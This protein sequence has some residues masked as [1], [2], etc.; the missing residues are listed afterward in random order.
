MENNSEENKVRK[1]IIRSL[2]GLLVGSLL[3]IFGLSLT[4][5]KAPMIV[6]YIIA[7]LLYI[8]SLLAVYNN[9]KKDKQIIYI[10]IMVVAIGIIAISTY[11]FINAF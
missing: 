4:G 1:V 7:M 9:N 2:A 3:F 8:S 10:Y 5:S 6:N 11:A